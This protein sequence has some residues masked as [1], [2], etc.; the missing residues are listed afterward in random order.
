[1]KQI[2]KY[3]LTQTASNTFEMPKGAKILTVQMQNEI[4]CIWAI[5]NIGTPSLSGESF[6]K[7]ERRTFKTVGTGRNFENADKAIYIGTIQAL[8]G[9]LVWHIFEITE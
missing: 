2:W 9:R 7:V 5:V 3:E 8:E 6:F 1:M 4:P